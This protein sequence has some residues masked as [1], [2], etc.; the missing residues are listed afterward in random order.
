VGGTAV[1][2]QLSAVAAERK[3][4]L[5]VARVQRV[6]AWCEGALLLTNSGENRM[7]CSSKST[8]WPW[9]AITFSR[10][11]FVVLTPVRSNT[12]RQW[13]CI[14]RSC[15]SE[16][17]LNV[18]DRGNER[19]GSDIASP[20]VRVRARVARPGVRAVT[21]VGSGIYPQGYIVRDLEDV[22]G[23]RR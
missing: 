22:G 8:C 4:E 13:S 5:G 3:V 11:R 7:R 6:R 16:R 15:S 20:R 17:T 19:I 9:S 23:S 12:R 18:L 1:G 2:R 21:A 10:F 14:A